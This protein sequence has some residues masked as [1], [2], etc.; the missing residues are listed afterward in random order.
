MRLL[1]SSATL[2]PG[3]KGHFA[4]QLHKGDELLIQFKDVRVRVL[5]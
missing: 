3:Q 4:L 2:A 1:R 5:D